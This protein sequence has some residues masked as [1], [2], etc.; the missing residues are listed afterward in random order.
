MQID[1]FFQLSD[2]FI[3]LY[4]ILRIVPSS[5]LCYYPFLDNLRFDRKI[6]LG[7]FSVFV[8]MEWLI[9]IYNGRNF[10][11][12]FLLFGYYLVYII[13]YL[14]AVKKHL[15]QQFFC[16][17][18]AANFE[19]V[20]Q[21]FSMVFE[22]YYG[23]HQYFYATGLCALLCFEGC[24]FLIFY[25][26][27]KKFKDIFLQAESK[28]LIVLCNYI[29][30]M[31]FAALVLIRDF[32]VPRNWNLCFSRLLCTLPLIIFIY[33]VIALLNEMHANKVINA[34]LSTLTALR[35]SEK[36]YYDFVIQT[37]QNSRRVRHDLKHYALLLNE[38]LEKKEYAKLQERLQKLLNYTNSLK[39]ISL[40]GNEIID[41]I[42][43]YW[44]LQAEEKQIDFTTEIG[45]NKIKIDDIDLS[46]VLG[47][48]LENAFTA[49]KNSV[50]EKPFI[51]LKL[52]EKAGLLLL[53]ISNNYSTP[54][55]IKDDKFYSGKREFNAPGTGVENI[56]L[57]VEKYQGYHKINIANNIFHLQLAMKNMERPQ[58]ANPNP[59]GEM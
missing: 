15:A 5:Y 35:N 59:Y 31:N 55:V 23:L 2:Y 28:R 41:G 13:F 8:L 40:S 22:Q 18:L 54:I 4:L 21:T 39:R 47:N 52:K 53:D 45:F 49:L 10:E 3:L 25:D 30:A 43:G 50:I 51:K 34:K 46:I 27:F 6:V 17:L 29:M 36:H 56:K 26:A 48:A 11:N 16:V 12:L 32:S 57:I 38:Y 42:V 9:Y 7:S 58:E 1:N 37:W 20:V 33:I 19:M 14:W 24:Y 44:Q